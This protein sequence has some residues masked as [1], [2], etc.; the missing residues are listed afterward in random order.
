MISSN[1]NTT[2]MIIFAFFLIVLLLMFVAYSILRA[3][4][5]Q[6]LSDSVRIAMINNRD[7]SARVNS[8]TLYAMDIPNFEKDVRQTRLSEINQG[9]SLAKLAGSPN[10]SAQF[11][12]YYLLQNN[13][14]YD[15]KTYQKRLA[16]GSNDVIKKN[17]EPTFVKA[18]TVD[19]TVAKGASNK[20]VTPKGEKVTTVNSGK[21]TRY[22]V[23]Y[24]V[25]GGLVENPTS[26]TQE[27][28]RL[29]QDSYQNPR[30]VRQM[31]GNDEKL[32]DNVMLNLTDH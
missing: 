20:R 19:V 14:L 29:L 28:S 2:T 21:G 18:V 5:T 6:S 23:T 26:T 30:H 17:G 1:I 13:E 4:N 32:K 7:D 8:K 12:F 9:W 22:S 24:I 10:G 16:A 3:N 15:T 31:V 25:D 11:K 27:A